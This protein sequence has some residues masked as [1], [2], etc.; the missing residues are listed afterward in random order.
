MDSSVQGGFAHRFLN[1]KAGKQ[2][3]VQEPN[4]DQS[5]Q[6][7]QG[8]LVLQLICDNSNAV[9]EELD[10]KQSGAL[11]ALLWAS[12]RRDAFVNSRK[13]DV[14]CPN[15][16]GEKLWLRSAKA[17]DYPQ[18]TRRFMRAGAN[19]K[20][21]D[22]QGQDG[23]SIMATRH[24]NKAM[25]VMLDE[26]SPQDRRK[27]ARYNPMRRP[28]PATEKSRCAVSEVLNA[29]DHK[30]ETALMKSV[31]AKNQM[32]TFLMTQYSAK[33]DQKDKNGQTALMRALQQG[34]A[35]A[36][37]RA[38][39]QL[40]K[41]DVQDDK[42]KTPLM[43]WFHQDGAPKSWQSQAAFWGENGILG[44]FNR[45]S[46]NQV[47][48][49]KLLAA[50]ERHF[51]LQDKQNQTALHYLLCSP[52]LDT[53][54]GL[55]ALG[56]FLRGSINPD[57]QDDDGVTP[58]ML[59][60]GHSFENEERQAKLT[61]DILSKTRRINRKDQ[62]GKTALSYAIENGNL[63]FAYHLIAVQGIAPDL[64]AFM[65]PE[66]LGN[67]LDVNSQDRQGYTPLM[68]LSELEPSRWEPS[69][70]S[71]L[72]HYY[73]AQRPQE[74]PDGVHPFEAIATAMI[75]K[76]GNLRAANAQGE[77]A[78]MIAA[79]LGNMPVVRV[80]A[81]QTASLE[82]GDRRGRT[83][84]QIAALNNQPQVVKELLLAGANINHSDIFGKT[85]LQLAQEAGHET[86]VDQLK[87][88][89]GKYNRLGQP[90]QLS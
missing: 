18:A 45:K 40:A 22:Q 65:L 46:V 28:T 9:I 5:Y 29:Q 38:L 30:G 33:I 17:G 13:M 39:R 73:V 2:S 79:R 48:T 61:T 20:A 74:L 27:K 11:P 76:G 43:H 75:Q 6:G 37:L 32:G 49:Q 42:G 63:A 83:A 55:D 8:Q 24:H 12:P 89:K 21:R 66:E 4:N 7:N 84:L 86:I 57:L 77:N 44:M 3:N 72:N 50:S 60:A 47:L 25:S 78:L 82:D 36:G 67:R 41:T 70:W 87:Q 51:N 68:R 15:P 81:K 26:L 69:I 52:N 16:D 90:I 80:L 56:T 85:A 58:L 31:S 35:Y 54:T 1:Q 10:A 14:D 34:D 59:L 53:P 19:I 23:L 71:V 88:C 62:Q 64:A